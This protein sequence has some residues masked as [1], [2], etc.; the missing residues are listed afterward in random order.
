MGSE[1]VAKTKPNENTQDWR[2]FYEDL[3]LRVVGTLSKGH[4]PRLSLAV[5]SASGNH[6]YAF[7]RESVL[8]Q[9]EDCTRIDDA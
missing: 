1:T 7:L 5:M 8:G 3:D 6:L 9:M 4:D 2:Q